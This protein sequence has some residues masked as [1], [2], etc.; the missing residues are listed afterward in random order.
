MFN[1]FEKAEKQYAR[2]SQNY[3]KCKMEGD[4]IVERV[5]GKSR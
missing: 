4:R 2:T 5:E 1:M 3:P